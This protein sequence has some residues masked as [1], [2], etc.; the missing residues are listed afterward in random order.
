MNA[1]IVGIM[2]HRKCILVTFLLYYFISYV[3]MRLIYDKC[4][5]FVNKI[6]MIFFFIS[7]NYMVSVED[8]F[9][10]MSFSYG[11]GWG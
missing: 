10:K 9:N 11:G 5:L 2:Y 4:K 8:K 3:A 6:C 7:R 1:Q